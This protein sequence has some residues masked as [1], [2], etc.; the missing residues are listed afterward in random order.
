MNN[1]QCPPELLKRISVL[2]M[3]KYLMIY[4]KILIEN[5]CYSFTFN[6]LSLIFYICSRL[7]I[8]I[9]Q[10]YHFEFYLKNCI[11]YYKKYAYS[12]LAFTNF[13]IDALLISPR[14][15]LLQDWNLLTPEERFVNVLK[16]FINQQMYY[17]QEGLQDIKPYNPILGEEFHCSWTH[18]DSVTTCVGE[19][20]S[21]HP[22]I[23]SLYLENKK[24]GF[25]FQQTVQPIST[26]YGTS[27]H[28]RL[29]GENLFKLV[30]L[31]EEYFY[32][33]PEANMKN[34][35]FGTSRLDLNN[36]MTLKCR[37]TG[38][39]CELT[40]PS[41][42]KV[43]SVEGIVYRKNNASNSQD[44]LYVEG[45]DTPLFKITGDMKI[46][47][48]ITSL[49]NKKIYNLPFEG[50]PRSPE[51]KMN[52]KPVVEQSPN[53]SRRVWHGVTYGL[54]KKD[55]IY[56]SDEKS[57]VENRERQIRKERPKDWNW[58]T[59]FHSKYFNRTEVI[60]DSS[61]PKFV[62]KTPL[63]EVVVVDQAEENMD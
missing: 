33:D 62:Y 37:K 9:Y 35:I 32:K 41:S 21:H 56:A 22:P 12:T 1:I 48:I 30:N 53:E 20:V 54:V 61:T 17:P 50:C 58:E 6:T 36:K 11:N 55:L 24:Y 44:D 15:F 34:L 2:E 40:F 63:S 13:M 52:V 25:Y 23:S 18:E 5:M 31:D 19:Q 26:F 57:K 7:P 27:V 14:S 59:H 43:T 42:P 38:I 3:C 47:V 51:F 49:Q 39:F 29:E 60:L 16:W 10:L 45:K 28:T 46:E 8:H 4:A